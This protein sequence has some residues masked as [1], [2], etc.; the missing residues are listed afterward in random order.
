MRLLL[1]FVVIAATTG[2]GSS[3]TKN[4]LC[5]YCESDSQCGGNPCFQDVSGASVCGAPCDPCPQGFSCVVLRGTSGALAKTCYPD[6][7]SCHQ[8]LAPDGGTST[9]PPPPD[10]GAPGIVVGGPVGPT[11]GTVDRL[12]F[13]MTGDTRPT[14]C[15]S[16]YP[17]GIID[18][19]FTE[20]K[21]QG[22]QFVV[23]QG[24]HLFNCSY[25]PAGLASARQQMAAYVS[26]ATLFGQT[27]FMTLGN[28]ECSGES[29]TLC[30]AQGSY[31][32]NPN[33]TAFMESLR[34]ISALP[35]YRV[36][37][38][39]S[40]GL[41][42]FL[43]VADDVWDSAEQSWLTQQ[44][45]DADLRAKYTFVSKHHPNRNTDHPEFQQIFDLV[46]A[47]K[48]TLFMTGHS[49][50]Y[51]HDSRDPRV[52]VMGVGGAPL[53]GGN[54]WGYGTV[55]QGPDDRIYV[56]IYDQATNHVEDQFDLAPQ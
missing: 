30:D 25:S 45:T 9:L 29:T 24:D 47:H 51:R 48:Y 10:G 1:L 35:Y 43:I 31:G 22:A 6:S 38:Q 40:T 18:N 50:Y 11:G 46:T 39:T 13:G 42:V 21:G 55:R 8:T 5:A 19:I 23:D 33:Y 52:L 3:R 12:L 14:D 2:C 36:D 41:A 7:E 28:H 16:A 49:H 32:P 4:A 53:S 37:V 44:L 34:P 26:A 15:G 56:T 54:F 27:V 17:T 20:L